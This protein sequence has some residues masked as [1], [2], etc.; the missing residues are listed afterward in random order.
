MTTMTYRSKN[1]WEAISGCKKCL[2]S[3]HLP[4]WMGWCLMLPMLLITS[5][6]NNNNGIDIEDP[7]FEEGIP[8]EVRITISSRPTNA[9]TRADETLKNPDGKPM[10]PTESIELIHNWWIVFIHQGTKQQPGSMEVVKIITDQDVT[11][12]VTSTSVNLT[13]GGYEAETFRTIIPSG[14]YR[15]Y[16]FANIPVFKDIFENPEKYK[17][18]DDKIKFRNGQLNNT[19]INDFIPD[20][21]RED[22]NSLNKDM[23]WFEK[24]V[25]NEGTTVNNNIPMTQVLKDIVIKN[26]VEEAFNI[27]VVRA[28]AKVEFEFTNP[29]PDEITVEEL[30]FGRITN[31]DQVSIVPNNGAVGFGPNSKLKDD[32]KENEKGT[33]QFPDLNKV[34]T[35][36]GGK[37]GLKFYCKEALGGYFTED[38]EA[39]T[40]QKDIADA[41]IKDVFKIELKVKKNGEELDPRTYYTKDITYI[42]RNDWIKIPITFTDWIIHWRMHYYPPIGG[43]PPL[44]EQSNDGTTVELVATTP[45]EFEFF[46]DIKNNTGSYVLTE[47]EWNDV[48]IVSCSETDLDGNALTA[49]KSLFFTRPTKQTAKGTVAGN[50]RYY[51]AGEFSNVE[52]KATVVIQFKLST[53]PYA[54]EIKTCTFNI[55]RKNGNP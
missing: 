37:D 24:I 14:T 5:C 39:V 12:K 8:T 41:A 11:D 27:E 45:G 1:R 46:S 3:F 22:N 30:K 40:A 42:N 16:A 32:I 21:F 43:Y 50:E 44:F 26:T 19:Y 38:G 9:Q 28:V 10:D 20:A 55:T 29:S 35:A 4:A 2:N 13:G 33:L 23:Q 36:R 48:S 52:G 47:T 15:I 53:G 6:T 34:L 49:G 25:N 31:V 7:D 18:K 51:I 17:D 54:N